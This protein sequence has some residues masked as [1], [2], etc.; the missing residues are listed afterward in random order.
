MQELNIK[1]G[2]HLDLGEGIVVR[3]VAAQGSQIKLGIAAPKHVAVHREEIYKRINPGH[4]VAR[5]C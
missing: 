3:V 1:V 4:R 5:A 2:D